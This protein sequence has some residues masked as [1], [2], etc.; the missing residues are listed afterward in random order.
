MKKPD[1]LSVDS[2]IELVGGLSLPGLA[3]V[4]LCKTSGLAGAAA[5]TST[6]ALLGGPTGMIGG[7]LG[8]GGAVILMKYISKYGADKVAEMY[9]KNLYKKGETKAT[10]IHK[11]NHWPLTADLKRKLCEQIELLP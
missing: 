3:F 8:F 4:L 9:I 10:I 6:L 1:F 2:F 7:I 5:M 11:I